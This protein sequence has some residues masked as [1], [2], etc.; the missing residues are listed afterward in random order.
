MPL[1]GSIFCKDK[2]RKSVEQ[3]R[4]RL[5]RLAYS[6]C[7]QREL[8]DDLVQETMMKALNNLRQLNNPDALKFWLNGILANCWKDHFRSKKDHENID[9]HIICD[10]DTP[11]RQYEQNHICETIRDAVAMLPVGQRQVVTLVDLE[12]TSYAEVAEILEIPIGTVMSRLCRARKTLS[13]TLL[14]MKPELRKN[15]LHLIREAK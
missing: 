4:P 5:Y 10:F 3:Q 13:E 14:E 9:E 11:E 8:A 15:N 2:I 7:H 12:Y 6:W 1:F